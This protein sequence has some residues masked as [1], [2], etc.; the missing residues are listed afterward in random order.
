MSHPFIERLIGTIRKEL[1]DQTFFWNQSDLEAKLTRF[2][3]YYNDVR[4]HY[5]LVG[6]TPN[7]KSINDLSDSC[8]FSGYHWKKYCNGLFELPVAA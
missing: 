3:N 4:C 2:M 8:K 1:L 7:E 5:S 6:K